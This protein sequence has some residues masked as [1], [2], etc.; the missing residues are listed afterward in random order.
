VRESGGRVCD[1]RGRGE[2]ILDAGQIVAG[3]Q[4]ICPTLQKAIVQTGYASAFDPPPM[5]RE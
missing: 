4:K 5:R 3:N 2:K 1:F